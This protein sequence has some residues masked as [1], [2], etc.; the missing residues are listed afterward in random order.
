M[1]HLWKHRQRL[2][3]GSAHNA[4][5]PRLG[6]QEWLGSRV[7]KKVMEASSDDA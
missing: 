6:I 3:V 5:Y 2:S 4:F 1:Q 7:R